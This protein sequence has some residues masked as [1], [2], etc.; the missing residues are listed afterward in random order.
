MTC[1]NCELQHR[2]DSAALE[3]ELA[4]MQTQLD[5]LTNVL[6]EA[7]AAY[8]QLCLLKAAWKDRA[9]SL[10]QFAMRLAQEMNSG[11]SVNELVK[12]ANKSHGSEMERQLWGTLLEK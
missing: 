8:G 2:E 5:Q 3:P 1:E 12:L 10:A 6:T 9:V 7:H 4:S 11:I